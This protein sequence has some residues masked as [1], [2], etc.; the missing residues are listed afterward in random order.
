MPIKVT[1]IGDE[2]HDREEWEDLLR[3]EYGTALGPIEF[4][5]E[6]IGEGWNLVRVIESAPTVRTGVRVDQ[7][8]R[9]IRTLRIGGKRVL[10]EGIDEADELET[11][12]AGA[13]SDR[14]ERARR[15]G[16]ADE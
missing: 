13:L 12:G 10:G 9:F 2:P 1:W 16:L 3:A 4:E 6:K 11:V 8:R 7:R 5:F 14:A 15:K